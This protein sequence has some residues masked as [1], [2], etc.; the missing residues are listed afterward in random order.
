VF[1]AQNAPTLSVADREAAEKLKGE[2]ED[3]VYNV[4]CCRKTLP[5]VQCFQTCYYRITVDGK[6]KTPKTNTT[7]QVGL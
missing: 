7:H 3:V 6:N 4:V 5:N 1:V 2:G